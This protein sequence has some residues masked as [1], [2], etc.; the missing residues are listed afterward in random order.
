RMTMLRTCWWL[1][2]LCLV[3]SAPGV[4]AQEESKAPELTDAKDKTPSDFARFVTVDDGGHFDVALTSYRNK[5]GVEVLLFG[6]VHIA[7][8]VHYEELQRRF[9]D[10]DALLYELVGP[11]DYRPKKGESRGGILSMFQTGLKN[12][13]ELEFQLD[14]IDYSMANFVHADMTPQEMEASMEERGESLFSMLLSLSMQGQAAARENAEEMAGLDLDI[15]KAFR[16]GRGRHKMRVML[17]SQLEMLEGMSAGGQGSTLLEGRNEKCLEVLQ[18]EL[19]NGKKKIGIY[20]GAAHMPHMEQRLVE[21][22]GFEKFDHEWLVAW[23]C[24]PRQDPKVDR[25]LWAQRRAAKR[26]IEKLAEAV[27]AWGRTN[28]GRLADAVPTLVDLAAKRDDGA[29]LYDGPAT[30]PWG[31]A[32]LVTHYPRW[33]YYDVHSLGQDGKADTEDD[34]HSSSKY[35]LGR[36]KRAAEEARDK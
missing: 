16:E 22:F 6:A 14:G 20:Y 10:R 11:E 27:A 17:A 25:E 30:D 4:V 8:G 36:M 23:D 21:D 29:A 5:D 19:D 32:Y 15:V 26:Q 31:N 28:E 12:G 9:V 35:R 34:L 2:P 3:A 7:D 33:P 18:R 13:L 1:L 24:T